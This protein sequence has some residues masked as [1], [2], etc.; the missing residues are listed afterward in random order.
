MLRRSILG[1]AVLILVLMTGAV[2]ADL[3]GKSSLSSEWVERFRDVVKLKT[4]AASHSVHLSS[5]V[6]SGWDISGAKLPGAQFENTEWKDVKLHHSV[7]RDVTFKKSL[8]QGVDF[9][10]ATLTDVTFEDVELRS[11]SFYKAKLQRV[12]FIRCK[13]NG[14]NVDEVVESTI[15]IIDSKVLSSSLSE[16]QL[17][18]TIKNST[19]KDIEFTDL[20]LPS[21]LTFENSDLKEINFSRSILEKLVLSNVI[22]KRGGFEKGTVNEIVIK[23]SEFGF[24][25]IEMKIKD[26][27]IDNSKIESPFH[28]TQIDHLVVRN[29][30]PMKQLMLYKTKLHNVEINQCKLNNFDVSGATIDS[31]H[32]TGGSITSGD[33][34]GAKIESLTFDSL[35]LIGKNTFENAQVKNLVIRNLSK[36]PTLQLITTGS[37][38]KIE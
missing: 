13:F 30:Q 34:A 8:M 14:I 19:L 24:G 9:Q 16:G 31:L 35:S 15:E 5:V 33:F 17:V 10:Q 38:V 6:I 37:N 28:R 26:F 23:D 7:L 11:T 20:E 36:D 4:Y 32:I 12:R 3:F 29:C 22:A 25:F 1:G 2:M 18:A 27:Q 21:S